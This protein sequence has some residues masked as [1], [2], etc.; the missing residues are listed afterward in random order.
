M[1]L[2]GKGKTEEW[3][4]FVDGYSN[5][6]GSGTCLLLENNTRIVVEMSLK[7]LFP[8]SNNQAK[9]EVCLAGLNLAEEMGTRHIKVKID[10]Q[11]VAS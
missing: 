9:Y 5:S 6:K 7:I 2:L 8:T 3:A 11:L 1:T 4:V 10:T